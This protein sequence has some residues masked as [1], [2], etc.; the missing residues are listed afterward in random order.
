MG[1]TGLDLGCEEFHGWAV[2]GM[3][4]ENEVEAVGGRKRRDRRIGMDALF[5]QMRGGSKHMALWG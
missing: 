3:I 4:R 5:M 1:S 2:D